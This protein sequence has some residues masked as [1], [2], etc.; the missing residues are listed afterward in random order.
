MGVLALEKGRLS[1][2]AT[3]TRSAPNHYQQ[4][5]CPQDR[6]VEFNETEETAEVEETDLLAEDE[7][8]EILVVNLE[9]REESGSDVDRV[10]E[11][12]LNAV[13]AMGSKPEEKNDSNAALQEYI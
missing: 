3:Y 2:T 13:F 9:R 10:Q 11:A 4:S 1:L 5:S 12:L 7:Y 8:A 6:K